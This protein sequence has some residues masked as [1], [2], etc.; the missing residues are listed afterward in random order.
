MPTPIAPWMHPPF[1]P[2][3]SNI[4]VGLAIANGGTIITVPAGRTWYGLVTLSGALTTAAAAVGA[5]GSVRAS[6][7]GAGAVPAA[8]DY[9]RLD[10][11]APGG[12]LGA[13]VGS[14]D[15]GQIQQSLYVSAPA[16][17]AVTLV[18]NSTNTTVQSASASG[19][20]L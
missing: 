7:A 18:M 6:T 15:S 17:N 16:T 12:V 2:D 1:N 13:L 9:V 10:L 4:L 14:Q 8:G 19:I 11:A 5:N 20:L 3:P